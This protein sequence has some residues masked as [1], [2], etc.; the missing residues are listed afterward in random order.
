[1]SNYQMVT[2]SFSRLYNMLQNSDFTPIKVKLSTGE[3][4]E[5]SPN[6]YASTLMKTKNQDDRRKIFEVQFSYYQ[7]HQNTLCSIYKGIVDSNIAK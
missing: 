2:S 3:E 6:T 1:M 7:K 4:V 5:V